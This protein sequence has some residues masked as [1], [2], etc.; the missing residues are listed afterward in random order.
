[1]IIAS[2]FIERRSRIKLRSASYP[3]L[4]KTKNQNPTKLITLKKISF[5]FIASIIGDIKHLI[6]THR[7]TNLNHKFYHSEFT[8][9]T[10]QH[11]Y[12]QEIPKVRV[13][14]YFNTPNGKASILVKSKSGHKINSSQNNKS[15]KKAYN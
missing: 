8:S 2:N 11:L 5:E 4:P 14:L 13:E 3:P 7:A 1:M 10:A 15:L 12:L 6:T 9:I